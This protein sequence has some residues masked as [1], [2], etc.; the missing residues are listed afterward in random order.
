MSMSRVEEAA[1]QT[2][3]YV[4][5]MLIGLAVLCLLYFAYFYGQ[6][7]ADEDEDTTQAAPSQLHVVVAGDDDDDTDDDATESEGDE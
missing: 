6:V 5:G 2:L 7:G 4:P 3:G 1:R